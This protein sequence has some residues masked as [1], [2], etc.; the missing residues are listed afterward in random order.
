MKTTWTIA[1][2]CLGLMLSSAAGGAE[3]QVSIGVRETGGTGPIGDNGGATGGIEFVNLNGQTLTADGTWQLFTFTPAEDTLTAFAGATANS[4]LDTEWGVLEQIRFQNTA[5]GFT[6][7]RVWID[8]ASNTDSA[9]TETIDFEGIPVGT[10]VAF[11]GPSFSGSTAGNLDT[12][13]WNSAGVDD[14]MAFA[15]S[16]SYLVEFEFVD[17]DPSRWLRLTTFNAAN[18]P[19]PLVHLSEPNAAAQPT[20]S[21]YAKAVAIPEPSTGIAVFLGGLAAIVMLRRSR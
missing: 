18:L 10:E 20:I 11:Q 8:D 3:L 9:G 1:L 17:D 12:S 7:Y 5:D 6:G 19:N 15:G 2:A 21:F 16:Q 14:S 13:T 4:I